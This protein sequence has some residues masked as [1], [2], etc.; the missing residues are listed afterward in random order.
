[1]KLLLKVEEV[2]V[3]ILVRVFSPPGWLESDRKVWL[4]PLFL[5]GS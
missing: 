2:G 4:L 3:I 1:M 5:I